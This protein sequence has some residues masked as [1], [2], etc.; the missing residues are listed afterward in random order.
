MRGTFFLTV[1]AVAAAVYVT[2]NAGDTVRSNVP[3]TVEAEVGDFA[4]RKA[5]VVE[6]ES[7]PASPDTPLLARFGSEERP[8]ALQSEVEPI[9]SAD[10]LVVAPVKEADL[11]VI[12]ALL[13]DAL[14]SH[15]WLERIY[16]EGE[17]RVSSGPYRGKSNRRS[18]EAALLRLEALEPGVGK[19]VETEEGYVIE[20][21]RFRDETSAGNWARRVAAE[22]KLE[23]MVIVRRPVSE[24]AELRLIF[25]GISVE[26]NAELRKKASGLPRGAGISVCR[27][28]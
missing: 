5:V 11:P 21:G 25:Q 28:P 7:Y 16:E 9:E 26:E 1:C 27:Q 13:S 24:R 14:M 2:L 10:C 20:L 18:A 3:A 15:V 4:Y 22:A 6:T 23:H 17:V 12:N 8:I 19:I